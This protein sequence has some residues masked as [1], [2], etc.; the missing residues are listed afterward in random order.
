MVA[1]RVYVEGG[2]DSRRLKRHCR[3]GFSELFR[4]VAPAGRMP[5]VVACGPRWS[6]YKVFCADLPKYQ[7]AFCMLLVD[8]EGA[9]REGV[10]PWASLKARA[11]DSWDKPKGAADDQA[12]LM[13]QCMEAWFLADRDSL[14]KYYGQGFRANALPART[15]IESISKDDLYRD[16]KEATRQAQSKGEYKEGSHAFDLLALIAP[17]LVREASPH[18]ERLFATLARVAE[19]RQRI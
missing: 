10:G 2:G 14:A 4:K 7:K 19:G 3:H 15:D 12:H 16:L 9:V 11:A 17:A 18:A 1:V 8:S 6:A 5:S 13:V